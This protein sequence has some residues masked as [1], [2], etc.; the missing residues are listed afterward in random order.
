MS[1]KFSYLFIVENN[2]FAWVLICVDLSPY[3]L[4]E[5]VPLV[6]NPEPSHHGSPFAIVI[7]L[8]FSVIFSSF[9]RVSCSKDAW[10]LQPIICI[11]K[12][13]RQSRKFSK[14]KRENR[15][16][17]S[18]WWMVKVDFLSVFR[19]SHHGTMWS[20]ILPLIETLCVCAQNLI[21]AALDIV[22]SN[23]VS[24]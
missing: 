10:Q 11:L 9:S 2:S 8:F 5:V 19:P 17:R 23:L 12:S 15:K 14:W 16:L 3:Q 13:C 7:V 24:K 18:R 6:L 1:V 21:R 4:G 20:C 22:G